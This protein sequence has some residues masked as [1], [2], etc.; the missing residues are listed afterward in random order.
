MRK[1]FLNFLMMAAVM[2]V[3]WVFLAPSCS[4]QTVHQPPPKQVDSL[5]RFLQ[6][7]LRDPVMGD[8]DETT[9]FIPAF[10]DLKGDGTQEVIVYVTGRNWCGSGGCTTLVLAPKGSSFKVV[11]KIFITRPPIR[12]L[13]TKSHGWY[14]I[15]V[16]MQGGGIIHPIEG[17]LSFNGRTYPISPDMPSARR[18]KEKVAGEVVIP[19]EAEG[20]PLY[21]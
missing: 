4:S 5:K 17:K 12:V 16:R 3:G 21:Q 10:V 6:D 19:L 11:T 2:A 8:D 14:D 15:A 18:L 13:T 7:Y 1:G 9:Q 20:K